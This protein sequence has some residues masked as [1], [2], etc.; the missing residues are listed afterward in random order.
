MGRSA[1]GLQD[2]QSQ[3]MCDIHRYLARLH[4]DFIRREYCKPSKPPPLNPRTFCYRSAAYLMPFTGYLH[5]YDHYFWSVVFILVVF[6]SHVI[7]FQLT[8][9]FAFCI[10]AHT[11]QP[12]SDVAY[13]L[14][15]TVRKTVTPAGILKSF[16]FLRHAILYIIKKNTC[17]VHRN[18]RKC[19]RIP[20]M[21]KK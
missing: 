7:A 16:D 17:T 1:D 11:S 20:F 10:Q 5:R 4:S 21:N 18:G 12:N 2:G 15:T 9:L 19:E 8:D 13:C 14:V 3:F 6:L